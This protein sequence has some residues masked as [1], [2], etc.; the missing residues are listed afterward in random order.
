MLPDT[1]VIV[2][3][4]SAMASMSLYLPSMTVG[5]RTMSN[6][7]ATSTMCSWMLMMAMSQP[8]HDAAPKMASLGFAAALAA[9]A[10]AL[11]DG[12]APPLDFATGLAPSRAV[13]L[14]GPPLPPAGDLPRGPAWRRRDSRAA[15]RRRQAARQGRARSLPRPRP[16]P[17]R[18][19]P[20]FRRPASHED[21][22]PSPPGYCGRSRRTGR[23]LRRRLPTP[24]E[25]V[26]A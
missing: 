25:A 11:V 6:A 5:H 16:G 20:R 13:G 3:S 12:L 22:Q 14:I 2:I 1:R 10:A 8:P 7:F 26:P 15:R 9:G 17:R 21:P 4:P 19:C 23:R 24:P 18:R